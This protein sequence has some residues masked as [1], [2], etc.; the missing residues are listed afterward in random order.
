MKARLIIRIS[1]VKGIYFF[2]FQRQFSCKRVDSQIPE[3][4]YALIFV[5]IHIFCMKKS[6][7]SLAFSENRATFA[8]TD[9]FL[10]ILISLDAL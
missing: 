2:I 8:C 10:G 5:Y 9:P 1:L 7:I 4:N 3:P 6:S